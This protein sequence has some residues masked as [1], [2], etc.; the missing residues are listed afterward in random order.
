MPWRLVLL[1]VVALAGSTMI[2][3]AT[4]GESAKSAAAKAFRLP[5]LNRCVQGSS[6]TVSFVPPENAAFAALTVRSGGREVLQL[7]GVTGPGRVRV[8]L[9]RGTSRVTVSGTTDGGLF[10]EGGQTYR[11]CSARTPAVT[12]P[13]VKAPARRTPERF[14][15]ET[16]G[17]TT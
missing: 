13:P 9:T 2:A 8:A 11:R 3:H 5:V 6:V 15:P 10:L 16:G 12:T 17:G 7:T 1:V 4:G 14:I